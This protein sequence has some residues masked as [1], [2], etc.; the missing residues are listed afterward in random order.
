MLIDAL[1]LRIKVIDVRKR[2]V[3]FVIKLGV[4]LFMLTHI[5]IMF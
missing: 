2:L 4:V 3:L 1:V 5:W